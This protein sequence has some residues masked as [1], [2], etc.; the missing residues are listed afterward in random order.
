[1]LTTLFRRKSSGNPSS[2][3][4]R[5]IEKSIEEITEMIEKEAIKLSP[6]DTGLLKGSIGSEFRKLVGKIWVNQP[7]AGFQEFGTYIMSA[8][9]KGKGYMLSLIHI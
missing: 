3:I 7:Y 8:A 2:G 5:G 1:M 4:Q 6:V 9:N